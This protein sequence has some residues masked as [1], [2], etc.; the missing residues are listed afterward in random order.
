MFALGWL[1]TTPFDISSGDLFLTL[2]FGVAYGLAS[3]SWIEGAKLLG[4]AEVGVLNSADI[5]IATL[6]AALLL[7]ELPSMPALFGAGV[8][9]A[10]LLLFSRWKLRQA[11]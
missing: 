2:A 9:V 4:A 10:A 3:I 7:K 11:D 6:L 1:V 8:V 5:P